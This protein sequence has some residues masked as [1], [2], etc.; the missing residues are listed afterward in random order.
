M[1]QGG[2]RTGGT[3]LHRLSPI[4]ITS[5]LPDD[6]READERAI[7][8]HLADLRGRVKA[9][10][11]VVSTTPGLAETQA[12]D[13]QKAAR[14]YARF[15]I[16]EGQFRRG[17]PPDGDVPVEATEFLGLSRGW[18]VEVRAC[19]SATLADSGSSVYAPSPS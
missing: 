7:A 15:G 19:A 6:S 9:A 10:R 2:E 3:D 11:A 17:V 12:S 1:G 5:G 8:R 16:S 13:W 14:F 18:N 4:D